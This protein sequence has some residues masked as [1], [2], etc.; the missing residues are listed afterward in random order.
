MGRLAQT[1]VMKQQQQVRQGCRGRIC[2]SLQTRLHHVSC[3]ET[4]LCMPKKLTA[5][6]TEAVDLLSDCWCGQ[7][8][9]PPAKRR[10]ESPT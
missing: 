9:Q 4:V 1:W 8:L 6:L 10:R 7:G 2:C 5:E 3:A